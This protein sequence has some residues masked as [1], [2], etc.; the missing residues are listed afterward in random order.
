MWHS[1]AVHKLQRS[2]EATFDRDRRVA[3]CPIL[4]GVTC[5]WLR[6]NTETARLAFDWNYCAT[7][8]EADALASCW[9]C[10]HTVPVDK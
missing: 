2:S 10:Q 4:E 5:A 8:Y 1:A 6:G 7:Q 3:S 9:Q